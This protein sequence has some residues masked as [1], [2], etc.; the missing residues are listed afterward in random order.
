MERIL[1]YYRENSEEMRFDI[2]GRKLEYFS[3]M[4][5]LEERLFDGA[6]ILDCAAGVGT[7]AFPLRQRGYDISASDISLDHVNHMH[8]RECNLK[9]GLRIFHCDAR[10]LKYFQNEEFD[11]VLTMGPGYHLKSKEEIEGCI[12]ENLR[13]LKHNGELL[14][15]YMGRHFWF[16]ELLFSKNKFK[17]KQAL[18]I[19]QNGFI[20]DIE[21]GFLSCAYF[22]T[23]EEMEEICEN[24]GCKIVEHRTIDCD[25]GH[26]YES[27]ENLTDKEYKALMGY[28][29]NI[30]ASKFM[31]GSGKNNI[32]IIRK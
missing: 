19:L 27:I 5:I 10:N 20:S 14:F 1:K 13:V 32:L 25:F 8:Q 31:A 30:S 3:V 21:E 15:S 26:F 11:F 6:K 18:Q 24:L 17:F 2:K 9:T 4:K 12:K 23:A 7:Y 16:I 22:S 28:V 29:V